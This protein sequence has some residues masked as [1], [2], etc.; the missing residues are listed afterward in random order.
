MRRPT[1]ASFQQLSFDST[2]DGCERYLQ[3]LSPSVYILFGVDLCLCQSLQKPP[4]VRVLFNR[5]LRYPISQHSL[6]L[7]AEYTPQTTMTFAE[8]AATKFIMRS[9]RSLHK[10]LKLPESLISEALL[11]PKFEDQTRGLS[12]VNSNL[13]SWNWCKALCGS[14]LPPLQ[15]NLFGK[16]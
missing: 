12:G 9:S 11:R 1:T 4:D 7:F 13:S 5:V 10:D 8:L 16:P 6:E 15:L 2:A 14:T 3:P